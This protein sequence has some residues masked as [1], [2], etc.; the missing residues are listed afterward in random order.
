MLEKFT[1]TLR[2]I[3][4][5]DI[6]LYEVCRKFERFLKEIFRNIYCVDK[7]IMK[8]E[9]GKILRYF[10]ENFVKI[11]NLSFENFFTKHALLTEHCCAG[12]RN[13]RRLSSLFSQNLS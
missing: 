5:S 7:V 3:D 2:K 11:I 9:S 12:F 6:N 10:N 4:E 1:R 13:F 8:T